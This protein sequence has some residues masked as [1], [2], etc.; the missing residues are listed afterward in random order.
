MDAHSLS[1]CSV[2]LTHHKV[3]H[4]LGASVIA[5]LCF[6]P[7]FFAQSDEPTTLTEALPHA[8]YLPLIHTM[9]EAPTVVLPRFWDPRL[10]ERG[11]GLVAAQVT[12]GEGYW[13]L[14]EARWFD[15]Q[16]AQGRHHI[17]IDLHDA[18]GERMINQPITVAWADGAATVITEAKTGEPYAANYPMYALAPAYSAKPNTGAPADQITGMGLGS[19]TEPYLAHHTSYGL[20]WEWA[21]AGEALT[22]TPT[23]TPTATPTVSLTVTLT[24]TTPITAT[25]T[26]TPAPENTHTPT[27]TATMTPIAIISAMP[28][29]Q[30]R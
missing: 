14:R 16:E 11:A 18:N 20:I 25:V 28:Q 29:R 27:V 13:H 1:L 9:A 2:K 5:L 12:P 26:A 30:Q 3:V 6:S 17:L 22:M 10:T 4:A 24:A 19:I 23:A 21:I 7:S 8:L 15:A